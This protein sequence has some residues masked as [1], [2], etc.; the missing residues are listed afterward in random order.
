MLPELFTRTLRFN[1]PPQRDFGAYDRLY[2]PR[3]NAR[4]SI[5]LPTPPLNGPLDMIQ[6][7]PTI[8][9]KSIAK[10]DVIA[11]DSEEELPKDVKVVDKAGR[12]DDSSDDASSDATTA[13][14]ISSEKKVL[15]ATE[16]VGSDPLLNAANLQDSDN[17]APNHTISVSSDIPPSISL[18]NVAL[19][20]SDKF[21]RAPN[22]MTES[23][24]TPKNI[25]SAC[26]P[27]QAVTIKGELPFYCFA[28]FDGHAGSDVA[29]AA[30]NQL[31][32]IIHKKLLNIADLLVAFSSEDDNSNLLSNKYKKQQLNTTPSPTHEQ[33]AIN[34][35]DSLWRA[36]D[37]IQANTQQDSLNPTPIIQDQMLNSHIRWQGSISPNGNKRVT[38]DNLITG[39]LESAFWDF[40]FL[41]E[42]DKVQY[43]MIGGCTA[44][45]SLFMLGKLYVANA[46]DSR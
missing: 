38:V 46:G 30:A 45:V 9:L 40:D 41:V 43:K 11:S 17:Y 1:D 37:R 15:K 5:M 31:H 27:E 21:V 22:P 35:T 33:T 2:T 44:I 32:K 24:S 10:P 28:L 36:I 14:V 8:K 20:A 34:S 6:P 39:A 25:S 18:Q 23:V 12:S 3:T 42:N 29:V 16:L 7:A 13:R 26:M 4:T 19:E